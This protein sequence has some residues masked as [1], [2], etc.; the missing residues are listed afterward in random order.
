ML[1]NTADIVQVLPPANELLPR[2]ILN[3]TLWKGSLWA[4]VQEMKTVEENFPSLIGNCGV[5]VLTASPYS[6]FL[7]ALAAEIADR[8]LDAVEK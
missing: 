8:R 3:M 4:L 5:Y 1:L 7:R 6:A 2:D